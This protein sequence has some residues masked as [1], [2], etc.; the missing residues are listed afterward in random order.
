MH[1]ADHEPTHRKN[2]NEPPIQGDIGIFTYR[3]LI[4]I[5]L[6]V[7]AFGIVGKIYSNHYWDHAQCTI[8]E[9][10]GMYQT[11]NWTTSLRNVPAIRTDEGHI[12]FKRRGSGVRFTDEYRSALWDK[13][14][15]N[16]Y[17]INCS[18][19]AINKPIAGIPLRRDAKQASRFTIPDSNS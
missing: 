17:R 5:G 4:L 1:E 12:V 14:T 7:V 19:P 2:D 16:R 13:H 15:E 3:E 11:Q 6:T 18:L 9:P 10:T 8:V